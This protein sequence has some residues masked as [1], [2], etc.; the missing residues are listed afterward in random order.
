MCSS[1]S[2]CILRLNYKDGMGLWQRYLISQTIHLVC[3]FPASLVS[4]H[5]PTDQRRRNR[6]SRVIG[7]HKFHK[8]GSCFER[9][10]QQNNLDAATISCIEGFHDAVRTYTGMILPRSLVSFCMAKRKKGKKEKQQNLLLLLI[11]FIARFEI[12]T[13]C[14]FW[15]SC[16]SVVIWYCDMN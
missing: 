15:Y 7:L 1:H 13:E 5:Q 9:S 11:N 3:W 8:H 12:W 2:I 10:K 16:H 6:Q 14:M 4:P